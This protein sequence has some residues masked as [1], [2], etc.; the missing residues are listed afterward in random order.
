VD[1]PWQ[2]VDLSHV[3][4]TFDSPSRTSRTNKPNRYA[5]NSTP[6]LLNTI[7]VSSE[8]R[9]KTSFRHVRDPD[10]RARHLAIPCLSALSSAR[11]FAFDSP[12]ASWMPIPFKLRHPHPIFVSPPPSSIHQDQSQTP[13]RRLSH[14]QSICHKTQQSAS[15]TPCSRLSVPP[16]NT[17]PNNHHGIQP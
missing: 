12:S 7:S 9:I 16:H 1:L 5:K 6:W 11:Q 3:L 15:S 4:P 17:K 10:I 8:V 2:V 14:C 13:A